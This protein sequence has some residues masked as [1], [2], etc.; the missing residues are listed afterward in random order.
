[1]KREY[2]HVDA[3]EKRVMEKV[4]AQKLLADQGEALKS[5]SLPAKS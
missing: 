5:I 3:W 2:T 1:M 4:K